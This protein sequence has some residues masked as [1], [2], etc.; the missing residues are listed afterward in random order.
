M[1]FLVIA[2]EDS[3]DRGNQ[4]NNVTGNDQFTFWLIRQQPPSSQLLLR[5]ELP[6]S[7]LSF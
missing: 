2:N 5:I 7:S 1:S 4:D 6:L 3:V